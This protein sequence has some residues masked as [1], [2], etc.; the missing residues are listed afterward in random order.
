MYGATAVIRRIRA[1]TGHVFPT[2]RGPSEVIESE[3][4]SAPGKNTR[5]L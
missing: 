5:W 2:G 3:R 4:E 1:S